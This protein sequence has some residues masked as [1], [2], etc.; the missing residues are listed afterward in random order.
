M[1]KIML[2]FGTRPEAI[3]MAPLVKE[4]QKYPD[5]FQ[6]IVCVTGQHREMLDQVLKI[7]EIIP[8]YDLNIMKQGQDL[9]D[10]TARVLTGMRNVLKECQPEVVLVHG[11][12]T[13][14]TA[15]ALAAFYQQIPVGHVEAG[16]RTHNIYSPWPEEMNCQLTGR[17]ATYHF[18]PTPLSRQNLLQEDVADEKIHVTGNTV[19]D[20]LYWVVKKIKENQS[21]RKELEGILSGAGYDVSRLIGGKKLILIT[22]HRRENFG[23]GFI[24]ICTA[25][26]DLAQKYP[27]VDFVYPMH[28]N[29]NVRKPIHEVFGKNL[30]GLGNMFF[31]EPL[32]YLSFVYL[33]EKSSIVLTDSGGI[34]EEAPG[35]GKPVLVMRDTTER[36]EA[37]TAGT[38]KLV[39]TDYDRISKEISALLEYPQ[40][41]EKMS[42]AVNPYGDGDACGRIVYFINGNR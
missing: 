4:F 10:V 38:V 20:A 27:N 32:E 34:Q 37:L 16:L 15:A 12:T 13:T 29:P 1:K 21:L 40:A 28:L 26:R 22:G 7:F 2:V 9:Y 42:K 33:M 3:K 36:P 6:T 31:I 14:S 39:G 25:I 35:L 23:E 8:D 41:Y 24:H 30:S 19:I 18:A 17:I 5:T 11:D